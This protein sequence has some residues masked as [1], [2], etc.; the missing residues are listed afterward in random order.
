MPDKTPV[1]KAAAKESA[2]FRKVTLRLV[3]FLFILYLVAYID[4]VNIGFAKLQMGADLGMGDLIYGF[5]AGVFFLGYFLFEVPSNIILHRVG[6]KIWIS[7][8]LVVWGLVCVGF[9]GVRSVAAFYWLRFLLGVAEAG[10]FPGMILYLTYWYPPARLAKVTAIFMASVAVA[11]VVGGGVSGWIMEGM[12]GSLG[13]RGWQWLFLLEGLPAVL[14]GV[15]AF[16][17]LDDSPDKALWLAPDERLSLLECLGRER[18]KTEHQSYA[19]FRQAL[20]SLRVWCLVLI[21]FC[22]V[23]GFYGVSFWL[24]QIVQDLGRGGLVA[25][26]WLSAIPYAIAV[27]VMIVEGQHSD[28]CGER[29]WHIA[30]CAWAAGLG[31]FALALVQAFPWWSIAALSVAMSGIL[32]AMATF[33]SLPSTFLSGRAAAGGIAMVNCLGNLGGYA[34]PVLLGWVRETLGHLDFGLHILAAVMFLAGGVVL[35]CVRDGDQ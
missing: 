11:G 2:V 34:G 31:L 16:L 29:R 33:W 28:Q 27:F 21:Y 13:L 24:P 22:L 9:M 30:L 14:L 1:L 18:S 4:R 17:Y 20:V 6:A 23:L 7:R 32:A 25:T 12:D 19:D 26:G 15:A 3:P 8:I 35:L 5:G 10:F